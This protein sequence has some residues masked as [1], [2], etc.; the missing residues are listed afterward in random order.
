MK[1]LAIPSVLE[2]I[3]SL[4]PILYEKGYFSF[5]DT[6]RKYVDEL[7]DDI[8]DNLPSKRYRPAPCYYDKYGNNHTE[9]HHLFE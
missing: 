3:D 7:S 4:V 9:A 1:V 2:Y 8:F 5:E 6:A